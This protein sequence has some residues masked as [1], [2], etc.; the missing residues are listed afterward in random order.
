[1]T[2]TMRAGLELFKE[3]NTKCWTALLL[4]AIVHLGR[5]G[6]YTLK[7]L[8]AWEI[9][10]LFG[11]YFIEEGIVSCPVEGPDRSV[12]KPSFFFVFVDLDLRSTDLR[13]YRFMD[14]SRS[15]MSQPK[16]RLGPQ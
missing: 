2:M 5:V 13:I 12:S 11:V 1:L 3:G 15:C 8:R 4:K 14:L 16:Y 7:E 9:S 6:E 10:R